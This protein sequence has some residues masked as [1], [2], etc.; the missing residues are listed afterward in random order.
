MP[1]AQHFFAPA[2][3]KIAFQAA[4]PIDEKFAVQ[5]IDFMLQGDREQP[6]GFDLDFFFIFIRSDDFHLRGAAHFGGEIDD[7]QT[8]FFPDDFSFGPSDHR[9][10][11]LVDLLAADFRDRYRGR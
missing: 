11:Q 5:M 4:D 9:I 6:F 3:V 10:D 2:T 7:A 1:V 8:A